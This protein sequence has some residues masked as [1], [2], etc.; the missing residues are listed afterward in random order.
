[1]ADVARALALVSCALLA[2]CATEMKK[3]ETDLAE[4]EA[5]LP[6]RYDNSEQVRAARTAHA[7]SSVTI[8]PIYIPTFGDHVFYLHESAMNDPR[9]VMTQRLLSFQATKGGVLETLYTLNEPGRWREGAAN[10]KMFTGMMFNDA[11]PMKGCDLLW[12]KDKSGTKF[13]AANPAGSCRAAVPALGGSVRLEMRGEL[14]ADT[15]ALAELA[16]NANGQL[17]QG[18]A[19][20]PFYRYR[21]RASAGN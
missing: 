11:L 6:G 13:E 1:M 4:I 16:Y 20:E 10:P 5:W 15:L 21:K 9:R 12:K 3:A 17:V 7:G 14:T 19:A 8:V 18:D 2:S